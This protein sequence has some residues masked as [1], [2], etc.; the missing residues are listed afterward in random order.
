MVSPNSIECSYTKLGR[1]VS[2][3]KFLLLGIPNTP[4]APH[5]FIK[6][7]LR[8]S[9][10]PAT[11][12]HLLQTTWHRARVR[13]SSW[14]NTSF[15]SS[16]HRSSRV[17]AIALP[18]VIN[19]ASSLTVGHLIF[20]SIFPIRF[21]AS[22]FSA[23]HTRCSRPTRS[24]RVPQTTGQRPSP[25]AGFWHV[26]AGTRPTETSIPPSAHFPW[27]FKRSPRSVCPQILPRGLTKKY[28]GHTKS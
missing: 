9:R 3:K 12:L 5:V 15:S 10:D 4:V 22:A 13:L 25:E 23:L 27:P 24:R 18:A 7:L 1:V 28:L 6:T 8:T 20:L 14:L 11:S 2:S 19:S 17:C 16:S 21:L 26:R